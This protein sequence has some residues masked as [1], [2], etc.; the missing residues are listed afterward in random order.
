VSLA[1]HGVLFCDELAEF[2]RGALEA[3]RQPIE[4]GVVA[5]ARARAKVTFPARP[6]LV[7]AMNPCPCG[8]RGD[9]TRRC[10][11]SRERV[12][13]YRGR[14]SGP[15]LDRIDVHVVMPP[16]DVGSLQGPPGEASALVAARVAAARAVQSERFTRGEVGAPLNAHL[17]GRDLDRVARLS[18]AGRRLLK[19]AVERLALSARAYQKILRVARTLADLESAD[20]VGPSHIAEAIGARVLDRP[21]GQADKTAA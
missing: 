19:G 3:L 10:L 13:A 2:R 16:V 21:A 11:C 18:S 15:L 7:C 14:L 5:V 20:A 6:L 8:Y 1:H 17:R 9:G 12:R 4:D